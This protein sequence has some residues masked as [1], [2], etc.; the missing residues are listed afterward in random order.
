MVFRPFFSKKEKI[1]HFDKTKVAYQIYPK[2]FKDTTGNGLGDFRGIIEKL[3]YL[4][5]LGVDMIWLILSIRVRNGQW[6][7]Y[8]TILRL[9]YLWRYGG[10]WRDGQGLIPKHGIDFMLIWFSIIA[11]LSMIGSKRHWL[12]IPTIR[13]F[14]SCDEPTDWLSKFGGSAWAPFGDTGKYYLHLYDVTLLT[15]IGA[16]PMFVKS[17]VV[18]FLAR[19][20]SQGFPLWC[21]QC[22]RK[23]E[24]LADCPEQEGKP[25]YT[26]K[27]IVHDY[28]RMMELCDLSAG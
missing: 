14:L 11:R 13:T 23:D 17:L 24:V 28:L 3:P 16:T 6:L 12:G 20:R 10:F 19:Q 21:H 27:P 8:L 2:S 1:W 7:W 9:T 15:S 5:E 4:K 26:D 25:A 22:Y 18:K